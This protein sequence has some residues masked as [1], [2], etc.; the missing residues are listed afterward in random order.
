M[1]DEERQAGAFNDLSA[2]RAAFLLWGGRRDLVDDAW[3]VKIKSAQG[4]DGGWGDGAGAA[5]NPHT[6]ALAAWALTQASGHCPL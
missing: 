6:T 2:E 1:H 5:P 3:L 4:P